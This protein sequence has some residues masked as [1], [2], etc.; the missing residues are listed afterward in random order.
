MRRQAQPILPYLYL[1]PSAA[2][3]DID[4]LKRE[5]ITLLLVIRST[6]TAAA[7]LLSGERVAS[8]LGIEATA[9]DVAW[10]PELIAAFPRIT[11]VINDHLI[12]VY[13]QRSTPSL[14]APNISPS[15]SPGK[16]LVFCE[17][18][19]ERSA[20]VVAAYLMAMH[21][22]DVVGAIQFIQSQRFCVAFD[23]SLKNLLYSYQ[24]LLE[25]QRSVSVAQRQQRAPS[26]GAKRARDDLTE[27]EDDMDLDYVG[28]VERFRGR[29]GF[30]AFYDDGAQ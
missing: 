23:D 19:N 12:S 8:Q 27:E 9:I 16:V 26:V 4:A 5:G 20:T 15:T 30:A 25:A 1:G 22:L 17:S 28:D 18:G 10:N 29:C 24:Q 13:R 7:R 6:M 11:K 14:S 2:A 3:R 21:D